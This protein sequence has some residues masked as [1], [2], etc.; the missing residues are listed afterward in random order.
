[1]AWLAVHE[2]V[3]TAKAMSPR[4]VNSDACGGRWL[5]LEWFVIGYVTEEMGS[6]RLLGT[7]GMASQP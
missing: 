1:M 4:R 5:A 7:H 3:D 6:A 2:F